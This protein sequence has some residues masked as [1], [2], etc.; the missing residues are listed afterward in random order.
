MDQ[1][2]D[3]APCCSKSGERR[4]HAEHSDLGPVLRQCKARNRWIR[5]FAWST[6]GV[7]LVCAVQLIAQ[8]F[9]A[10]ITSPAGSLSVESQGVKT[11]TE[12]AK[13]G[14]MGF[15]FFPTGGIC[16]GGRFATCFKRGGLALSEP[17]IRAFVFGAV[18]LEERFSDPFPVGGGGFGEGS[19]NAGL[20]G[21][22]CFSDGFAGVAVRGGIGFGVGFADGGFRRAAGFA[23]AIARVFA[24]DGGRGVDFGVTVAERFDAGADALA[25]R[26]AELP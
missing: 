15:H 19:F 5:P 8:R 7:G 1:S 20:P 22:V 24:W 14:S 9:V 18:D 26:P 4:N 17:L 12:V 3:V 16:L 10:G 13:C 2:V 6:A 25:T 21:G 11:A 23:A